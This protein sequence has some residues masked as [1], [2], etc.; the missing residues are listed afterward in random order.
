MQK[1]KLEKNSK[2]KKGGEDTELALQDLER[3]QRYSATSGVAQ[4]P[5][6]KHT[7]SVPEDG[8]PQAKKKRGTKKPKALGTGVNAIPVG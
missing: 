1:K 6:K 4:A 5:S 2:K 3:P 7:W 8:K